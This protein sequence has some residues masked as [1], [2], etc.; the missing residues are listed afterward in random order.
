MFNKVKDLGSIDRK[1]LENENIMLYAFLFSFCISLIFGKS[2]ISFLQN[3]QGKGQPIRDDGPETHHSKSGTPTMGGLMI[4]F[5][6]LASSLFFI[7]FSNPYILLIWFVILSHAALGFMD[8]YLKVTKATVAGVRGK[9]KLLCQCLISIIAC[10]VIQKF[11]PDIY[12]NQIFLPFLKEYPIDLGYLYMP[13]VLF[14]IIGSSN[15][16]NLTDGL[17]GLVTVP[18]A[19]AFAFFAFIATSSIIPEASEI[20]P[21]C[22]ALIGGLLGFLWYNAHPAQIFMGD[23]GSLALGAGLGVTSVILKHEFWLAIVGLLFVIETLSVIIQV[24]YF[25]ISGGKRIFRMA[26]I[27]H[28]FEKLGMHE[29]KVVTRFWIFSFICFLI[30]VMML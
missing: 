5:S 3:L 12:Q 29:V 24:Y 8:D 6:A 11:S 19:L 2:F 21:L 30:G 4:I 28:H 25:K 9:I 7:D 15:A 14:V 10:L 1:D 16:V 18:A 23:V 22:A 27:H 13:F 20:A 26:P 17:D